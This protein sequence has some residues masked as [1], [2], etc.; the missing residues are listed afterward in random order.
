MCGAEHRR[1]YFLPLNLSKWLR[2]VEKLHFSVPCT[3]M[4]VALAV[5]IDM[6]FVDLYAASEDFCTRLNISN[7]LCFDIDIGVSLS[8]KCRMP[9]FISMSRGTIGNFFCLIM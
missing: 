9:H 8:Q 7:V 3:V 1:G 2:N 5:D 4:T 6:F